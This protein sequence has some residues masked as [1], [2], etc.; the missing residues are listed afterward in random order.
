M[1]KQVQLPNPKGKYSVGYFDSFFNYKS[2][3]EDRS[4][5]YRCYY[6]AKATKG[7]PV[8]Y[9]IDDEMVELF[10]R[11]NPNGPF[12]DITKTFSNLLTHSY[13][14]APLIENQEPFK[15][16][17]YSHSFGSLPWANLVQIE[18]L[19]S[20]GYVVVV[21]SHTGDT[22]CT[23]LGD[24]KIEQNQDINIKMR[25]QLVQVM[26]ETGTN[27]FVYT[28]E[29]IQNYIRKCTYS[30]ER[31]NVWTENIMGLIDE[32]ENINKNTEHIFYDRLD[33]TEIG[34]FG[35]SF[36][37]A[38]AI[39]TALF[40]KRIIAAIN[41]DGFQLGGNLIDKRLEVPGLFITKFGGHYEGNYGAHN[42]MVGCLTIEG[43]SNLFMS[44]YCILFE[45]GVR[46][47]DNPTI[48][49]E[50]MSEILTESVLT[51]FNNNVKKDKSVVLS[52]LSNRY[53]EISITK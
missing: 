23:L 25:E 36:G 33:Y 8:N 32:L 44:D 20:Q 41:I 17:I 43:S 2:E 26:M 19:S 42:D 50:L 5:G 51:F 12:N 11:Q 7:L 3:N 9:Y 4:I 46:A 16:V 35:N 24:K 38:A 37:G 48:D 1:N 27:P 18:E 34:A 22:F 47:L 28:T 45:E 53:K 30:T 6:P 31:V 13:E 49:G 15:V 21:I 29:Q 52:D 39:N 14:N 10:L 40:D